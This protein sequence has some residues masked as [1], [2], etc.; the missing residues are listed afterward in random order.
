MI[1]TG[2]YSAK[3]SVNCPMSKLLVFALCKSIRYQAK[4]VLL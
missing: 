1:P 4:Y 2:S 3:T